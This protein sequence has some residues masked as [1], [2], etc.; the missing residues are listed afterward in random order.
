MQARTLIIVVQAKT[1]ND[2]QKMDSVIASFTALEATLGTCM[3][4]VPYISTNKGGV[5]PKF[6]AL[7]L[8]SCSLAESVLKHFSGDDTRR[9]TLRD[10]SQ[11]HEPFLELEAA[12]TLLPVS[13]V[14]FLRPFKG[15]T[16]NV[17]VWW[18]A[19]NQLKHD[20]IAN[21]AAAS[22][23]NTVSAL[24]GLNQLIARTRL[25]LGNMVKAGWFNE[26]DDAFMDMLAARCADCGPPEMPVE[27]RLFVSPIR[28]DFVRYENGTSTIDT[29]WDFSF[30]VRNL[31][32]EDEEA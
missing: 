21:Y 10:Y 4:Y 27:S 1:M 28:G 16:K 14:Q 24:A 13:P 19:Y 20:R 23:D 30:H 11:L 17:P 32:F 15:W 6:V 9:Y 7:I 8:E 25:F 3:E 26:E 5:S 2:Q 29:E 22:Y 12:T 31:I 18:S